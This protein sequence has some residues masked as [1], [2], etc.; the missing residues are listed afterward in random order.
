MLDLPA[1]SQSGAET[2]PLAQ[3]LAQTFAR[4]ADGSGVGL[5]LRGFGLAARVLA[6]TLAFILLAMGLFY[7]TRLVA[8][9]EMW[10][11]NK[12][13]AAQTAVEAFNADG[14]DAPARGLVAK[15]TEQRR[16]Q[17]D[18]DRDAGWPPRARSSRFLPRRRGA[19][20]GRRQ[21]LSREYRSDVP[22]ALRLPGKNRKARLPVA[23][24][25]DGDR[26]DVRRDAPD[27]EFVAR[28]A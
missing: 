17:V 15:N 8:Y 3:A 9:R 28:L 7:L 6:V 27:R 22:R 18:R 26:G 13:A 25:P 12:I 24:G 10:L 21:F 5:P 1:R 20:H 14:A 19:D 4:Q 2:P 23:T 16:R 11:H